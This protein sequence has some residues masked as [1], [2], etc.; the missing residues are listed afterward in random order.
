MTSRPVPARAVAIGLLA[1]ALPH[2]L[3]GQGCVGTMD[4]GAR[5][6]FATVGSFRYELDPAVQGTE[7]GGGIA[8]DLGL[9]NA[10]AGATLRTTD[11][12][13]TLLVARGD[14]FVETPP[15]PVVGRLCIAGGLGV[16]RLDEAERNTA[17]TNISAPLGLR[18]GTRV[19]LGSLQA[20]PFVQPQAVFAATTGEVFGIDVASSAVGARIDAGTTLRTGRLVLGLTARYT[21]I[22][23][24]LGPHAGADL[25]ILARIALR[26]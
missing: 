17:S 2:A 25:G 23:P 4:A 24:A 16:A 5:A 9:V 26:F 6:A 19:Q 20:E 10:E 3:Q 22:D 21:S 15:L 14:A 1:V 11:S 7:L 12:D 18:L 13:A 8:A